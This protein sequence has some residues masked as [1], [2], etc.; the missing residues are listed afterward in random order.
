MGTKA[1]KSESRNVYKAGFIGNT[2]PA[3]HPPKVT[4]GL[5]NPLN[6]L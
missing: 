6:G 5:S 1:V 2:K 4:A 3:S